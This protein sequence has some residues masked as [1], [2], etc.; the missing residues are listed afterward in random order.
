M[1]AETKAGMK[2]G[3][4]AEMSVDM[5]VVKMVASMVVWMVEMKAD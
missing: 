4:M 5:K 3:E 1:M 2:V